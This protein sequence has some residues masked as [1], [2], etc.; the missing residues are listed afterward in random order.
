MHSSRVLLPA[1]LLLGFGRFAQ[2]AAAQRADSMGRAVKD[3]VSADAPVIV[4]THV[5]LIDGTGTPPREDQ[6]VVI[7][8]GRIRAVGNASEIKAPADARVIDLS[9]H[10]LLPGFVGLHDHLFY[11]AAGG[12]SAQLSYTAPRLYLG[13]GV[14]TIRTTGSRAPYAEL[15]LKAEIEKGRVPGPRIHVTAPYITGG[16]G[17]SQMTLLTS[18]EQATRFVAYWA[19]EGA[20]WLKAY[21]DIR[22]AE[23]KA[24]IDEA[25]RQGIKVTGHLCSV[26]YTE[27]VELGID[28]LEHGLFTNSDYV[29]DKQPDV[30]PT[31]MVAAGAA[32]KPTDPAVQKTF[33]ALIDKQVPVT[34]TLAVYELFV[35]NRPTRDPRALE[36]MAPE[37]REDYLRARQ[38]IDS[39]GQARFT[40]EVFRNGMAYERAFV[41]AGGLLAAGVDPTGNGGALPG[42][43]DQR[44]FEL[45]REAG[46]TPEQVVQIMTLNGA[47]ILG[48]DKELGSVEQGKLADLVVVRGDVVT[49]PAAI[50]NVVT[51]FKDGIG[52][53]SAKLFALVKGRVGIN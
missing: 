37:V 5:K 14:T 13:A 24:A 17:M 12:R 35:P 51:V 31:S 27:A 19:K 48:V 20:T 3:V 28:N 18:P 47:R 26:S 29:T 22:R 11:T 45:L 21:T 33:K 50:K 38:Q 53:D 2:P 52:Y 32:V 39:S 4:L 41:A 10:S 1:L 7:E 46:F 36:A 40:L 44:N 9:G 16:E 49:D 8:N 42:Y 34:S 23:L 30:C 15:N 6:T 43:G 25:H